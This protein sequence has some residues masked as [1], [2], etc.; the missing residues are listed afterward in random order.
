MPNTFE[1]ADAAANAI[2]TFNA[3]LAARLRKC[4][5][6]EPMLPLVRSAY[7]QWID[8]SHRLRLPANAAGRSTLKVI[9]VLLE[10]LLSEELR[11]VRNDLER[12]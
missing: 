3:K 5:S 11:F 6:P 2:E 12:M 10:E 4:C 9:A 8:E 7:Y 1:L